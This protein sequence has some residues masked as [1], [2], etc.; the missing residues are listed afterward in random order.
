MYKIYTDS[1]EWK[2]WP[3]TEKEKKEVLATYH[4]SEVP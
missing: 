3:G 1:T 4:F 2:F